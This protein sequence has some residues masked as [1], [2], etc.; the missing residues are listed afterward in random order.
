MDPG[1][2]RVIMDCWDPLKLRQYMGDPA[3]AAKLKMLVDAG[4]LKFA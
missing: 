1:M 4:L 3:M 2:Q